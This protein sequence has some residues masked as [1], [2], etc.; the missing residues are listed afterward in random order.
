MGLKCLTR[1]CF[2]YFDTFFTYFRYHDPIKDIFRYSNSFKISQD[3]FYDILRY[4]L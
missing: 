1:Y 2:R 3:I 4:S